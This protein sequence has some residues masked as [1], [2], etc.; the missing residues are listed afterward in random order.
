MHLYKGA[1]VDSFYML[2][3]GV[4]ISFLVN[5]ANFLTAFGF[6]EPSYYASVGIFVWLYVQSIDVILRIGLN[7]SSRRNEL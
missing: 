6:Y 2:I 4:F 7:W 3:F 5:D 1:I